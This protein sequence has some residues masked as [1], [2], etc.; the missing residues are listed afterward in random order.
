MK[1]ST[2]ERNKWMQHMRALVERVL[3]SGNAGRVVFIVRQ[4]IPLA[5]I[6]F[7]SDCAKKLV[8]IRA[9]WT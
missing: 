1:Y 6:P 7:T 4:K 2:H 3:I 9:Y 8:P 5:A